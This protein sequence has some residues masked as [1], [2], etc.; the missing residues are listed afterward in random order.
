MAP[1]PAPPG[2][3][4]VFLFSTSLV[5]SGTTLIRVGR[6]GYPGNVLFGQVFFANNVFVVASVLY[7]Q[8]SELILS[9][10]VDSAGSWVQIPF[11]TRI[12]LSLLFFLLFIGLCPFWRLRIEENRRQSKLSDQVN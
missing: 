1:S 7:W 12:F 8:L 11:G 3:C 2:Q 9:P 6:E 10:I 4:C 5:D